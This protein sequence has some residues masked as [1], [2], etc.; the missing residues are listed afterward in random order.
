MSYPFLFEWDGDDYMIP[1]TSSKKTVELYRALEF[2]MR[3]EFQKNLMEDVAAVDATLFPYGGRWWLFT[4]IRENDGG[5]KSEELFLF[6]AESPLSDRWVPHPENPV[7]SDVTRSRPAGPLFESNGILYRPSQDCARGYGY[8]IR[9]NQ[10]VTLN[11]NVYREVEVSYIEPRWDP[12]VTGV[13]TMQH[14]GRLTLFD[15]K[16]RRVRQLKQLFRKE[17]Q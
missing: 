7:V 1:E 6:S 13:H 16:F 12:K 8:G 4:N 9:L 17:P 5:S 3:W 15:A 11:E 10:V 2:P 14:E